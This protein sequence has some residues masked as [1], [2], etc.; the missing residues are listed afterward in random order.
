M[1]ALRAAIILILAG[2]ATPALAERITCESHGNGAEA[3]GTVA[4]GSSVRLV[5]QLS[6]A[7][8]VEGRSWGT[9]PDHDSI[10]VSGGCRAVFDV[11]AP[12]SDSRDEPRADDPASRERADAYA[13][14]DDGADRDADAD[15]DD[16][17]DYADRGDDEDYADRDDDDAVNAGDERGDDRYD[18]RDDDRYSG[19]RYASTDRLRSQARGACVDQA[20]RDGRFDA[21]EVE[22]TDERWLGNGRFSVDL[23]TPDGLVVCTVD[24]DG[25]V[26]SLDDR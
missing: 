14:R 10:W 19:S 9:G 24:G 6:G 3:C 4:A 8:C 13:D 26:T 23:D 18:D 2:S 25:N 1:S 11:D 21:N 16:E 17:G 15:R 12:Y 7:P 22:P 20:A 5:Q